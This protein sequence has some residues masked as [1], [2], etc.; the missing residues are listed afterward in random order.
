[1]CSSSATTQASRKARGRRFAALPRDPDARPGALE[2]GA[3]TLTVLCAK[4]A[5]SMA[6]WPPDRPVVARR[7]DDRHVSILAALEAFTALRHRRCQ[8]CWSVLRRRAAGPGAMQELVEDLARV[9]RAHVDVADDLA[10][11]PLAVDGV[12]HELLLARELLGADGV[13]R[14]LVAQEDL[15]EVDRLLDEPP[16]VDPAEALH[17]DRRHGKPELRGLGLID[18]CPSRR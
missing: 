5:R 10:H 7:A 15:V 14:H 9:E 17:D 12:E 2:L 4:Q 11:R 8:L 3:S 18:G 6:R 1:M 13:E 16:L